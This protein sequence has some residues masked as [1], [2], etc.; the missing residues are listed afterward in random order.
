V[1]ILVDTDVLLDVA[2]DRAPFADG[3]VAVLDRVETGV[4]R[5]FVAWHTMA[6]LYY[7]L[8][9]QH[10]HGRSVTFLRELAGVVQVAPTTSS[11]LAAAMSLPMRDL[12]DAMQVGA[13]LA[14]SADAIVT[15]NVRD[16][17]RSPVPAVRPD[18]YLRG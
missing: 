15:R 14:C 4:D 1:I 11:H 5:G 6:N 2:L 10:G 13:A 8:R 18:A 16:F 7:L 3:A 17:R 12:E 9:P